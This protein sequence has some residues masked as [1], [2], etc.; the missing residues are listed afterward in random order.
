MG[1]ILQPC[2]LVYN[3]RKVEVAPVKFVEIQ[4]LLLPLEFSHCFDLISGRLISWQEVTAGQLSRK[5]RMGTNSVS[6]NEL[7]TKKLNTVFLFWIISI[8]VDPLLYYAIGIDD[9]KKCFVRNYLLIGFLFFFYTV[10]IL[11][12]ICCL[13]ACPCSKRLCVFVL[14]QSCWDILVYVRQTLLQFY[15][16]SVCICMFSLLLVHIYFTYMN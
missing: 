4:S 16:C 15:Y 8:S 3:S 2:Q 9:D 6:K 7:P 5:R 1:I 11:F 14:D 12:R 10:F 13:V